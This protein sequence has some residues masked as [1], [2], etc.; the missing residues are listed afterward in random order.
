L[1]LNLSVEYGV[2]EEICVP[3][4]GSTSALLDMGLVQNQA[5][6]QGAIEKRSRPAADRS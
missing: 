6:I 2:C 3:A 4:Y 1:S 5:A